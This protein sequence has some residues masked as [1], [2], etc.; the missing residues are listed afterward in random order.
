MDELRLLT[1]LGMLA[2]AEAALR[3]DF[4]ERVG[5]RERD[6]VSRAFR[7]VSKSRGETIRLEE[8][9]L[10][11]WREHG[12]IVGDA[13]IGRAIEDFKGA[14]NLRHWLAHGRYWK[15]TLG[16]AAGYDPLEVFNISNQLLEAVGLTG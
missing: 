15:A 7:N 10:D 1:M 5:Y 13:R 2:C 4:I 3:I 9:I 6:D 16:R 8:D 14:F 11:V 12:R